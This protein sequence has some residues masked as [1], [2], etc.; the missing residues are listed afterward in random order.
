MVSLSNIFE[1][2]THTEI[3][4]Y[5]CSSLEPLV[6]WV[7]GCTDSKVVVP[8]QVSKCPQ[9]YQLPQGLSGSKF[10]GTSAIPSQ[11]DGEKL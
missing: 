11:K 9:P 10:W 8:R 1:V 5:L 7:T 3:K 6:T 2:M 4:Q